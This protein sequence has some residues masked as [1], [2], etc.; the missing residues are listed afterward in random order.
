VY[1]NPDSRHE[2]LAHD[3][4]QA[5]N[6]LRADNAHADSSTLGDPFLLDH[7]F[8]SLTAIEVSK[9]F[10]DA[11]AKRLAEL[12]IGTWEGPIESG[13]GHHLVLLQE[14]TDGR[15]PVLEEARTAV[16]D[17][18]MNEERLR[19]NAAFY[20]SLLQRY[21]VVIEEPKDGDSTS[22]TATMQ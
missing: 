9:L 5:L 7:R 11:F 12:P 17:E 15:V 2:H 14:R 20:Q 8:E 3:A 1:F 21:K 22:S 13:Y 19:A 18:W 10:G 16:S 4:Q 6:S